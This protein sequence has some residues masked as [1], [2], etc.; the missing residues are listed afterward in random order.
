M[1]TP[2]PIKELVFSPA[3]PRGEFFLDNVSQHSFQV[4]D[5]GTQLIQRLTFRI[6]QPPVLELVALL[7]SRSNDAAGN[8]DHSR[9][10]GN[11]LHNYRAR[12][13]FYVIADQNIPENLRPSADD[14]VISYGWV[15]L[16]L[17]FPRAA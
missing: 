7:R 17:L 9:I 14:Y 4:I 8:A 16:A 6:R 3:L 2:L 10:I 5:A 15:P 13:D 1:L 12:A 11:W